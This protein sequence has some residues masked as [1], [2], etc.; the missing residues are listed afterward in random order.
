MPGKVLISD[1]PLNAMDVMREVAP[2]GLDITVARAGSPEFAA[3]LAEA[4]FLIGLSEFRTDDAF[5]KSAPKLKLLQLLSAGYD[6]IDIE[7]ARRAGVP[8]CNNGGAN[9]VAVAEH[10]LML[11]LAVSRR[12]VW[13]HRMVVS[14]SWRG[15]D[16]AS[17][18]L[19][20]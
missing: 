18:R 6:R 12:M 14:G 4:E 13:Q 20:E 3:A 11:M 17:V 16:V 1:N 19:Y 2:A 7:A 8:V 10:A 5:F 15:N 9:S